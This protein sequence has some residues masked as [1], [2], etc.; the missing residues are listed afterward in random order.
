VD[1]SLS[2]ENIIWDKMLTGDRDALGKLMYSYFRPLANYGLR[3]TTDKEVIK[4]SIQELFI[5]V[6]ERRS[7]LAVAVNVKSYLFSSFRRLL[8][9]T[10]KKMHKTA[11]LTLD[12]S[13]LENF[14]L[15]IGV[16]D[17]IIQTEHAIKLSKHFNILISRLPERQKEVVYLK[18]FE[19]LSREEISHI[20]E[21]APQTVSNIL[22]IALG[23]LRQGTP[24]SLWKALLIPLFVSFIEIFIK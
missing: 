11:T 21:I 15:I 18:F 19:S 8:L 7:H 13:Y 2:N 9:R 14:A 24:V 12:S 17:K 3:F 6:W 16:D 20:L 4:D 1:F 10:L 22:Q 5:V 23:K